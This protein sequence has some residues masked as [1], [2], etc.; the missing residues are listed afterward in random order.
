MANVNV[1][2]SVNTGSIV[3]P[4]VDDFCTFGQGNGVSNENYTTQASVGDTISWQGVSSSSPAT[5]VVNITSINYSGG[6]NI[7]DQN[8]INGNNGNPEKVIATV[9]SNTQ[10]EEEE[11]TI[12]FTVFN[13]STRRNGSFSIDPKIQ[14]NP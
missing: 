9:A 5:D 12:N 13:G 7:F 4:N 10:N 3:N 14:V 11:Y 1:T 8:V 2:L 6:Q